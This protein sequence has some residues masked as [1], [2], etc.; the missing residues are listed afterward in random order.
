[1]CVCCALRK[2][3]VIPPGVEQLQRLPTQQ[4]GSFAG[5]NA[6]HTGERLMESFE[7]GFMLLG[8]IPSFPGPETETAPCCLQHP[9]TVEQTEERRAAPGAGLRC[10]GGRIGHHGW[11][12][13]GG[14]GTQVNDVVHLWYM[15]ITPAR[16]R[17][18]SG[19]PH[20][21]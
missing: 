17:P 11:R 16:L 14:L 2:K 9:E 6:W 4:A 7:C 5:C 8:Q 13:R 15:G 20:Q 21:T 18:G 12:G 19:M 1:M 3:V 10:R